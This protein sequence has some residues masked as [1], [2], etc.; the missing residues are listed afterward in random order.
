MIL[1]EN[2]RKEVVGV[3]E[4]DYDIRRAKE[5]FRIRGSIYYADSKKLRQK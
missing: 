3:D 4:Y 5:I 1:K 2:H